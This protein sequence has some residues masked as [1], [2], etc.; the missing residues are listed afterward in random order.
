MKLKGKV[1]LITGASSGI[2][3]ATAVLLAREGVA[4]AAAAR[5][6]DR[7]AQLGEQVAAEGGTLLPLELDVTDE[8]SRSDALA[9]TVDE[10]GVPDIVVNNAGVMLLGPVLRADPADWR[11]MIE[12][13]VLGLMYLSQSAFRLMAERRSGDIVQVSSV[14]G[15]SAAA[16]SAAYNA[17]KWAVNG[18]SEGLRQEALRYGVRVSVVEP[19][20]VQTELPDHI[21]DDR[22]RARVQEAYT[23]L[24]PLTAED[25]A[26]AI[27]YAVSRPPHVAVGELLIRPAEQL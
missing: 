25:V 11:R 8:E 22:T 9:R 18:F 16:G 13:N 21:P 6:A 19:G 23:A 10:L 3:A 24:T 27:V 20:I 12:T 2:G 15:R 17:S 14:A 1:A 26:E 7:L 4:V 5:R